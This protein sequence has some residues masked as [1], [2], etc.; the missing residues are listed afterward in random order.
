MLDKGDMMKQS[1]RKGL[2]R[3]KFAVQLICW[4]AI[5]FLVLNTNSICAGLV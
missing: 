4:V 3:H 1:K 5:R 2:E